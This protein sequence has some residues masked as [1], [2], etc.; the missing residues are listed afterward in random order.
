VCADEKRVVSI[1]TKD[2]Y[3]WSSDHSSQVPNPYKLGCAM[4]VILKLI[5]CL[6]FDKKLLGIYMSAGMRFLLLI[7]HGNKWL[8]AP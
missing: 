8:G 1:L 5:L 6:F 4:S 3:V 7:I 2:G